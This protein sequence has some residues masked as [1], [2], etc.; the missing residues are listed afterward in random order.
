MLALVNL[1]LSLLLDR[2]HPFSLWFKA[3]EDD[4]IA[5]AGLASVLHVMEKAVVGVNLGHTR[6]FPGKETALHAP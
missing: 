4:L 6:T 5:N 2:N 3:L 1:P